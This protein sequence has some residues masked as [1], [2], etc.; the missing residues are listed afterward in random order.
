MIMG[1]G[2]YGAFKRLREV[3]LIAAT[4]NVMEKKS[5]YYSSVGKVVAP[6][7]S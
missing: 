1:S 6:K 5:G 7:T 2:R 4:S 3:F